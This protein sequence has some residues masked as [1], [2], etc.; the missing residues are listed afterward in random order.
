MFLLSF[1]LWDFSHSR[2]QKHTSIPTII[3]HPNHLNP[4][5]S[6]QSF[7]SKPQ[8]LIC[9]SRTYSY[10][11]FDNRKENASSI[12][13]LNK[14]TDYYWSRGTGTGTGFHKVNFS[15]CCNKLSQNLYPTFSGL[16]RIPDPLPLPLTNSTT[17]GNQN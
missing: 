6:S 11:Y 12:G 14:F 13:F 8:T 5:S 7:K 9:N 3:P 2:Y 15:C 4:S 16:C 1:F 10:I 17:F